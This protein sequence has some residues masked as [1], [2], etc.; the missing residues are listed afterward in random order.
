MNVGRHL[1][2]MNAVMQR[3]EQLQDEGF[4]GGVTKE[5]QKE[6][7]RRSTART[8]RG[9]KAGTGGTAESEEAVKEARAAWDSKMKEFMQRG[10]EA[11]AQQPKETMREFRER[12]ARACLPE[13]RHWKYICCACGGAAHDAT[14][15]SCISPQSAAHAD[16][17]VRT[18]FRV[19]LDDTIEEGEDGRVEL[20]LKATSDTLYV[21]K[22]LQATTGEGGTETTTMAH[23]YP[24]VVWGEKQVEG[25]TCEIENADFFAAVLSCTKGGLAFDNPDKM[26]VYTGTVHGTPYQTDGVEDLTYRVGTEQ[27]KVQVSL[28]LANES[29]LNT[30]KEGDRELTVVRDWERCQLELESDGTVSTRQAETGGVLWSEGTQVRVFYGTTPQEKASYSKWKHRRPRMWNAEERPD[31]TT[32]DGLREIAREARQVV[33]HVTIGRNDTAYFDP[34]APRFTVGCDT[35]L[36]ESGH[37]AIKKPMLGV[38]VT[39][40][41]THE[42][43]TKLNSRAFALAETAAQRIDVSTVEHVVGQC[44]LPGCIPYKCRVIRKQGGRLEFR[45]GDCANRRKR[46]GKETTLEWRKYQHDK[47]FDSTRYTTMLEKK[48]VEEYTLDHVMSAFGHC[49]SGPDSIKMWALQVAAIDDGGKWCE[50]ID[51]QELELRIAIV[52]A[53]IYTVEV[54]NKE[55]GGP[56]FLADYD[57]KDTEEENVIICGACHT[58]CTR[59]DKG[60]SCTEVWWGQWRVPRSKCEN[61]GQIH[62]CT[63]Q[64]CSSRGVRRACMDCVKN[65]SEMQKVYIQRVEDV[66]EEIQTHV[67]E[68][69]ECERAETMASGHP[70][71]N[72]AKKHRGRGYTT[73]AQDGR[74]TGIPPPGA[75]TR[76]ESPDVVDMVPWCNVSAEGLELVEMAHTRQAAAPE[77]AATDSLRP[78]SKRRGE[79]DEVDEAPLEDQDEIER[80]TIR[81]K[82]LQKEFRRARGA[83]NTSWTAVPEGTEGRDRGTVCTNAEDFE[84]VRNIPFNEDARLSWRHERLIQQAAQ[85]DEYPALMATV[86]QQ[87]S[88][89]TQKIADGHHELLPCFVSEWQDVWLLLLTDF[90]R[91]D[92]K[93][94]CMDCMWRRPQNSNMSAAEWCAKEEHTGQRAFFQH[95]KG[96]RDKAKWLFIAQ[97]HKYYKKV[98]NPG[99]SKEEAAL[100]F[101]ELGMAFAP[102]VGSP[103]CYQYGAALKEPGWVNKFFK[104]DVAEMEAEHGEKMTVEEYRTRLVR[105]F[106][107]APRTAEDKRTWK[108]FKT[109][110]ARLTSIVKSRAKKRGAVGDKTQVETQRTKKDV[111]KRKKQKKPQ[112][113]RG[114]AGGVSRT[115]LNDLAAVAATESVQLFPGEDHQ[116][117][118]LGGASW[119]CIKQARRK[120]TS[121]FGNSQF[122]ASVEEVKALEDGRREGR[123]F[124]PETVIAET[125]IGRWSAEIGKQVEAHNSRAEPIGGT[126]DRAQVKIHE[127]TQGRCTE[128]LGKM[129]GEKFQG[130]HR[131]ATKVAEITSREDIAVY[132]IDFSDIKQAS[133]TAQWACRKTMHSGTARVLLV[134]RGTSSMAHCIGLVADERMKMEEWDTL[135]KHRRAKLDGRVVDD[136]TRNCARSQSTRVPEDFE[137]RI[138]LCCGIQHKPMVCENT[139]TIPGLCST[140]YC[141]RCWREERTDCK[142]RSRRIVD[143]QRHK[144]FVHRAQSDS[145]VIP[146]PTFRHC[147][148]E[149]QLTL[150][151]R[152]DDRTLLVGGCG[153]EAE[154]SGAEAEG[155]QTMQK[156]D[157]TV[158]KRDGCSHCEFDRV[159]TPEVDGETVSEG[160]SMAEEPESCLFGLGLGYERGEMAD[161]LKYWCA[162]AREAME[163]MN[164]SEEDGKKVEA[165]PIDRTRGISVPAMEW[166]IFD[167]ECEMSD[168]ERAWCKSM[169][170][171]NPKPTLLTLPWSAIEKIYTYEREFSVQDI[172]SRDEMDQHLMRLAKER[173]DAAGMYHLYMVSDWWRA[174][175]RANKGT[176]QLRQGNWRELIYKPTYEDMSLPLES[177]PDTHCAIHAIR[178]LVFARETYISEDGETIHVV[179]ETDDPGEEDWVGD[180]LIGQFGAYR[181]ETSVTQAPPAN[182]VIYN[183][184]KVYRIGLGF[185][186][187]TH[188]AVYKIGLEEIAECLTECTR[189]RH[190]RRLALQATKTRMKLNATAT[191]VNTYRQPGS[192]VQKGASFRFEAEGKKLTRMTEGNGPTC[193]VGGPQHDTSEV[194]VPATDHIVHRA[195]QLLHDLSLSF[196]RG[197]SLNITAVVLDLKFRMER[198]YQSAYEDSP[199]GGTGAKAQSRQR[200][201]VGSNRSGRLPMHSV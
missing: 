93:Q 95:I 40:Q 185:A 123:T 153:T 126:G 73:K 55:N 25:E 195:P 41:S 29:T 162:P 67:R 28:Q 177:E 16:A 31:A 52:L 72:Q 174:K 110:Y 158:E 155:S 81:T 53:G 74:T 201:G 51:K 14:C 33:E 63:Q 160:A 165:F 169:S 167:G 89:I 38:G 188:C 106:A 147:M 127:N 115:S 37:V 103:V 77:M 173:C 71:V 1:Y 85:L 107:R 90:G 24:G 124:N 99:L 8:Q 131:Q 6:L 22:E 66:D 198:W 175:L 34:R 47:G 179:S 42:E 191:Q 156:R 94:Y 136:H 119:N 46:G 137:R 141:D 86:A 9:H 32:E 96:W 102:T 19:E 59:M 56:R 171:T 183:A 125:R 109:E 189:G 139:S 44:S 30:L 3:C 36:P 114:E 128:V 108:A 140:V 12:Q 166:M 100:C 164:L 182:A 154:G 17:F 170:A 135:L 54:R 92:M 10:I 146:S 64:G 149:P 192:H 4:V 84:R 91:A 121:L 116:V 130:E 176:R 118:V 35:Q 20:C 113:A 79:V 18:A 50:R 172:P 122:E 152:D 65:A 7:S 138:C 196:P 151:S 27:Q 184:G 157:P 82:E 48:A 132:C 21:L 57:A 178:G 45:H 87:N 143:W 39:N 168:K 112:A 83:A 70:A 15:G 186:S 105:G 193:G 49:M 142:D 161:K 2:R 180:L 26:E 58:T 133:D 148:L 159:V 150:F 76:L 5:A 60:K 144:V 134:A 13:E 145:S 11:V 117:D 61:K 163:R 78:K 98:F 197:F 75:T 68:A 187:Y 104:A 181:T 88:L 129:L 80:L 69:V 97:Q 62:E 199:Q 190:R 43:T 23:L 194:H 120:R 101:L 111:V 200:E